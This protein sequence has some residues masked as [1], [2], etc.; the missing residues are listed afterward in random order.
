MPHAS[1]ARALPKPPQDCLPCIV[2]PSCP[3]HVCTFRL[4]ELSLLVLPLGLPLGPL[5][6]IRPVRPVQQPNPPKVHV[7]ALMMAVVL[8][9]RA[10]QEVVAAVHRRRLDQL[11]GHKRPH[12]Q[13]VRA[14][15]QRRQR[16]GQ[17]IGDDVLDRV[18]VLRGKGHGRREAVVRLV[19]AP[20]EDA[21]VQQP[22]RVVEEHLAR[23]DA[24]RQV[25]HEAGGRGQRGVDTHGWHAALR[26]RGIAEAEVQRRDER[27]VARR[28]GDGAPD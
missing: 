24:Q 26:V 12:G 28:H 17:R 2:L 4:R 27:L 21:H 15:H 20:V 14:Q 8:P 18:R 25:A 22:V 9:R 6:L 5:P 10:A 11:P 7:K 3:S 19:D 16:H 23:G 1:Y 13:H